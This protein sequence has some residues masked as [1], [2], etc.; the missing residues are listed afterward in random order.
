MFK[1]GRHEK[2]KKHYHKLVKL[3]HIYIYPIL[4]LLGRAVF[5]MALA[6][7]LQPLGRDYSLHLSSRTAH[8]HRHA[9]CAEPESGRECASHLGPV[10]AVL[11]LPAKVVVVSN[12]VVIVSIMIHALIDFFL[13]KGVARKNASSR[14]KC[15]LSLAKRG[16]T[17]SS[18][19]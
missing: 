12:L 13:I 4:Y 9:S 19:G 3:I 5:A 2:H 8:F 6:R 1:T 17:K 18:L 14:E 11:A 10:I 7:G 16:G 15:C